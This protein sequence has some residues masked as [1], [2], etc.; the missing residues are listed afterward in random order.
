MN[1]LIRHAIRYYGHDPNPMELLAFRLLP[2][3]ISEMTTKDGTKVVI[4]EY[5]KN[6]DTKGRFAPGSGIAGKSDSYYDQ[7]ILNKEDI[8]VVQSYTDG[9]NYSVNESLRR[10]G[11]ADDDVL[12]KLDKLTNSY[13]LKK[14]T[15]LYRGVFDSAGWNRNRKWDGIK[16]GDILTD[17]GFAATTFKKSV[18]E[19]FSGKYIDATD[20]YDPDFKTYVFRFKAPKGTKGAPVSAGNNGESE[21]LMPRGLKVKVN[22]VTREGN[23]AIIDGEML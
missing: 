4:S 6:H 8:S 1:K 7:Y 5:N 9:W 17:L 2:T 21:W 16:K 14:D 18:A 22:F 11:S 12:K 13:T 15:T 23:S 3:Q 10:G 19:K 20:Q